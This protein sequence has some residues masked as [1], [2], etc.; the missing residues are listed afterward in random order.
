MYIYFHLAG[1]S[2]GLEPLTSVHLQVPRGQ[3]AHCTICRSVLR[4]IYSD[5]YFEM[6][7]NNSNFNTGVKGSVSPCTTSLKSQLKENVTIVGMRSHHVP[8]QT[9]RFY[10]KHIR[11]CS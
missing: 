5:F 3:S 1:P 7:L 6:A 10:S 8:L 11:N 2:R 9:R 4:S